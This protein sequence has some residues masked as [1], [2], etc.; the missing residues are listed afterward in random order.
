M[1]EIPT[2][3]LGGTVMNRLVPLRIWGPR[4]GSAEYGNRH[5]IDLMKRMCG[6]RAG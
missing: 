1:G 3:W 6:H 2:F 4:G 5:A